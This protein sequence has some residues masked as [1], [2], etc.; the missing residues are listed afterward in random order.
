MVRVGVV[1]LGYWGPNLVRVLS[2]FPDCEVAAV[3]DLNPR[4]LHNFQRKFPAVRMA[5]TCARTS[6]PATS[7]TRSS[8]PRRRRRI[9]PWRRK[10]CN[11]LHCFVEKPLA[12]S[13]HDCDR[14]IALA[15]GENLSL[16][17]GHVFLY[18]APVAKLKE[19][20]NN[21]QLGDL[22]YISSCRRNLG[23]VR[24][25]VRRPLA[26]RRTTSPSCSTWWAAAR[27]A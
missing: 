27:S 12:T 2:G 6:S 23:P 17:V 25:N 9:S 14:L 19:M 11:G 5:T 16:F 3:C 15:E 10:P 7:S 13:S 22:Y 21:G 8:S 26:L 4:R 18:S 24:H 1:G 20:V